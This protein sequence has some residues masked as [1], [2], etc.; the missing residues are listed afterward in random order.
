MKRK[1]LDFDWRILASWERWIAMDADG[2]WYAYKDKP[3][4]FVFGQIWGPQGHMYARISAENAP[5][6]YTGDWKDS[7]FRVPAVDVPNLNT[8]KRRIA[9]VK[10]VLRWL[11]VL[12]VAV[13]V[14]IISI[15]GMFKLADYMCAEQWPPVWAAIVILCAG[16]SAGCAVNYITNPA[17]YR[18]KNKRGE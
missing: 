10:S 4:L 16:A 15:L 17:N 11:S 5:K 13:W 7:L 3:A 6:N 14:L 8:I 1:D 12:S 9:R 2:H 18:T